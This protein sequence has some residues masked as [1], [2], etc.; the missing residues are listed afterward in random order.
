MATKRRAKSGPKRPGPEPERL[1]IKGGWEKALRRV[2]RK[3][4]QEKKPK[5]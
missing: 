1:K 3:P 4:D 5:P 2:L